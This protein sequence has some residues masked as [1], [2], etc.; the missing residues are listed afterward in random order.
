M[1]RPDKMILKALLL[2]G[3]VALVVA[4]PLR[5]Q[6]GH[7]SWGPW[8]FDWEVVG[9]RGLGIR[10]VRFEDTLFLYK[11]NLPVIRVKYVNDNWLTGCGPYQ[12]RIQWKHLQPTTCSSS[13]IC[14]QS[15]T[16]GGIN[17][18]ELG[19]FAKIGKY[20]IYQAWYFGDN[21]QI[22]V[23]VFSRGWACEM[24]HAH[25]PYWRLDIDAAGT[26][27]NQ[28]L[29]VQNSGNTLYA[30]EQ[31]DSKFP[32]GNKRWLVRARPT[33]RGLWILPGG[34]DGTADGYSTKD[35]GPRLYQGGEDQDWPFGAWG[36]LGYDNGESL[37]NQDVVFWYVA[38]MPH[39][40]TEG[41]ED[42]GNREPWHEVGP[43]LMVDRNPASRRQSVV[44]V[45]SS[46]CL[47]VAGGSTADRANVQ[48]FGCHGGPNQL[49][50]FTNL[51]EFVNANSGKCLDVENGSSANGAN[52]QQYPCHAGPSQRWRMTAQGEIVNVQNGK[53]LDVAGASM[54]DGGNV[55]QSACNGGSNQ[56]WRLQG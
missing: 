30:V 44:G 1:L 32:P 19:A 16:S 24:T 15:F 14:Q 8:S 17:W 42:L 3:A 13:K 18:L 27:T 28:V 20:R 41:A 34:G 29:A 39:P 6:S 37:N 54:A 22:M 51:G 40:Y 36:H 47:D 5:A 4:G 12:D 7:S 31:N 53:C 45:G 21:G 9:K 2:T 23:R 55:Q 43:T 10:N 26:S 33:D 52:V 56:K 48:Q 46:K 11:A 38:H 49:W 50:S 35:A 25:H